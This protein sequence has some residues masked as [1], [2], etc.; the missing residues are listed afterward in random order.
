MQQQRAEGAEVALQDLSDSYKYCVK[1]Q[2]DV[3]F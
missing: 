1:Q 3:N 2:G